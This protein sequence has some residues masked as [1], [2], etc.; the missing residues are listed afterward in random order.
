MIRSSLR[1][2]SLAWEG[3]RV[4]SSPCTGGEIVLTDPCV[5]RKSLHRCDTRLRPLVGKQYR[6]QGSED[7]P[8]ATTAAAVKKSNKNDKLAWPFMSCTSLGVLGH[9]LARL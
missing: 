9:P 7:S 2:V 1:C 4:L 6:A 3:A 5:F 8:V